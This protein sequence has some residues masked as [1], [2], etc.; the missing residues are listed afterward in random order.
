MNASHIQVGLCDLCFLICT[1]ILFHAFRSRVKDALLGH[2]L[3]IARTNAP[4]QCFAD[5]AG[6]DFNWEFLHKL[7]HFYRKL[8]QF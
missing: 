8:V 5:L 2:R 3:Q 6:G 4:H 7:T 1:Y